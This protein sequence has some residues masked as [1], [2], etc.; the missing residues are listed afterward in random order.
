MPVD[1]MATCVTPSASNQARNAWR[2]RVIVS[3]VRTSFHTR[4][5]SPTRRTHATT[6]CLWTSRPHTHGYRVSIATPPF[7]SVCTGDVAEPVSL[8]RVLP[9]LLGRQSG[10]PSDIRVTLLSGFGAPSQNRPPPPAHSARPHTLS[11]S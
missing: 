2:L 3:N 6:V 7:A 8:L 9:Q 1:S 5:P 10:V 4:P 11:Q